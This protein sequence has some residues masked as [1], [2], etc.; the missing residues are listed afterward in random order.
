MRNIFKGDE[1]LI[2]KCL[3]SAASACDLYSD[4]AVPTDCISPHRTQSE[5]HGQNRNRTH[6]PQ[7]PDSVWTRR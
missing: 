1:I 6:S 3:A 2:L 4:H 5:Q 7:S